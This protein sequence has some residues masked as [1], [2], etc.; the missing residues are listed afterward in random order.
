MSIA[1]KLMHGRNHI[2]ENLNGWG[3][4]GPVIGPIS[5]FHVTYNANCSLGIQH[6]SYIEE[7]GMIDFKDEDGGLFYYKGAYYGDWEIISYN[8]AIDNYDVEFPKK[9]YFIDEN[10]YYMEVKKYLESFNKDISHIFINEIKEH[11]QSG[12]S[13]QDCGKKCLEVIKNKEKE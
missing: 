4:D 13:P 12:V 3:F 10:D 5:Y 7:V 9:A 6:E 8:F 1:I 11:H 2:D